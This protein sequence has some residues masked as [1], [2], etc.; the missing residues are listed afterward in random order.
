MGVVSHVS[1]SAQ[2][3]W[4]S[5]QHSEGCRAGAV[6]DA[7]CFFWTNRF[8]FVSASNMGRALVYAVLVCLGASFDHRPVK[9]TCQRL[10]TS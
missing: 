9:D 8:R 3:F 10:E 4:S 5:E 6:G 7:T 2:K 1:A